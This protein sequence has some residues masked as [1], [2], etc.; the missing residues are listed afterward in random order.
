[1]SSNHNEMDDSRTNG[2]ENHNSISIFNPDNNQINYSQ[3]EYQNLTTPMK[4]VPAQLIE[5]ESQSILSKLL[6]LDFD[7]PKEQGKLGLKNLGNTCYMNCALQVLVHTK[8]LVLYFAKDEYM[9]ELENKE[10]DCEEALRLE[11]VKSFANLVKE[12]WSNSKKDVINPIE[13]RSSLV[14]LYPF[15]SEN[16]QQDAH[17]VLTCILDSL[18]QY[19]N[20]RDNKFDLIS[21]PN[22]GLAR[23]LSQKCWESHLEMNDSVIT[24]LFFGQLKSTIKCQS[25]KF[26][27]SAFDPFSSLGLPIPNEYKILVY[28]VPIKK[29]NK[30][31]KL[32]LK[33]NDNMQFKYLINLVRFNID[34]KF[35]S[36]IFYFV[37]NN[38]LIKLIDLDERCGDL[39]N[40]PAFLFL[41]E[42]EEKETLISNQETN[43]E[44]KFYICLNFMMT[45]PQMDNSISKTASFPRIFSFNYS[46]LQ[47]ETFNMDQGT[48]REEYEIDDRKI[49]QK[50]FDNLLNYVK[51]FVQG[52][53]D[54]NELYLNNLIKISV[55][56]VEK[57]TTTEI[58][59][60]SDVT[61]VCLFCDKEGEESF[62]CPCID[63]LI[64]L[65]ENS[66][67]LDNL[68]NINSSTLYYYIKNRKDHTDF[69]LE[70]NVIISKDIIKYKEL[71]RCKD[72]TQ[73][74]QVETRLD[75]FNLLDYFTAEEKLTLQ[76]NY[77]CQQC[78]KNVI[79]LK[80]MEI[81]KFPHILAI[82]L[83]R[84]RLESLGNFGRVRVSRRND[85]GSINQIN[86]S[87]EKNESLVEFPLNTLDLSKYCNKSTNIVYE[88]F[89]VCNHTG[90][91]HSGH[92]TAVC[93]HPISKKWVE[94]D[95][96]IIRN[97][98]S[99]DTI[100]SSNAYMLFY[101]K[102]Q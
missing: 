36:G 89:A 81:N 18:H 25:C 78:G 6:K 53:E 92:Y 27:N 61:F 77:H 17:E 95:D 85:L 22:L 23:H 9:K 41:I 54:I 102:K 64:F 3:Q 29:N 67:S 13:L 74:F 40:R 52:G 7:F 86:F 50:L 57:I 31:I 55:K 101:R 56:S 37:L 34:Y 46:R 99:P 60:N 94:F 76:D 32:F 98:K 68:Y 44:D 14:K 87:G 100:V 1:M 43:T 65:Q 39:M 26:E 69:I 59:K 58:S 21:N 38:K 4:N 30:P 71:N 51:Q 63:K 83:K 47:S 73:K 2:A 49:I 91:M 72:I 35:N 42:E 84:F 33:I 11:F 12:E 93:K 45:D 24:D 82:H 79:A 62:V 70:V 16:T 96:K 48:T 97:E 75:L 5:N 28:F 19:L 8:E 88:L 10:P 20:R 80:K 15:F 90:T 66:F